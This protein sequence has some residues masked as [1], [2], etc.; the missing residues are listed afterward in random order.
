MITGYIKELVEESDTC[1]N[2]NGELSMEIKTYT[3]AQQTKS[4]YG[5][6]G[7]FFADKTFFKT[8]GEPLY[9]EPGSIWFVMFEGTMVTGFCTAFQKKKHILL[10][11]FFVLDQYKGKGCGSK[12]FNARLKYLKDMGELRAMVKDEKSLHL[13][14]KNGFVIYGQRGYYNLVKKV[15]G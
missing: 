3:E 8:F 1:S 5:L 10:N 12:L 9:N 15:N 4:F 2:N 11:Q 13:Y 7:P 14:K 6:M